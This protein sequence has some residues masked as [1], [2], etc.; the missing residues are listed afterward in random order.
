MLY[1]TENV[2]F[3]AAAEAVV[4]LTF[5]RDEKRRRFLVVERAFRLVVFSGFLKF[6]VRRK[7][8]NDRK[9]LLD[10]FYSGRHE[11]SARPLH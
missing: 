10:L 1:K 3:G 6:D 11:T 8:I 4:T 2:S 9:L 5:R 7:H